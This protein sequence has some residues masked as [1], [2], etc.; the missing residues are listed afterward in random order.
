M[1]QRRLRESS[2]VALFVAID[3]L[4]DLNGWNVLNDW[5]FPK[6]GLLDVLDKTKADR[7][8]PQPWVGP[9]PKR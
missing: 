4:I 2:D 7:V 9:A 3:G 1:T 5:N 8:A 6:E